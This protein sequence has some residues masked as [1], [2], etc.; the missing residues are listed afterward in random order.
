MFSSK[1]RIWLNR[2]RFSHTAWLIL[3]LLVGLAFIPSRQARADTPV[4]GSISTDTTWDLA[5]SPY[6]LTGSVTVLQN[7]TLTIEPG[8]VVQGQSNASLY[9]DGNLQALGQAGNPIVFTSQSDSAA[10]QWTGIQFSDGYGR[11]ENVIVR[12]GTINIDITSIQGGQELRIENSTLADPDDVS[13]DIPASYLHQMQM[14][15]NTFAGSAAR[16]RV[17]VSAGPIDGDVTLPA[18]PGLDAYQLGSFL[19][20]PTETVLTIEPGV[21][22]KTPA[23]SYLN[24]NGGLQAVGTPTEPITFTSTLDS[25]AD[26]WDGIQFNGGYGHLNYTTVRYGNQNIDIGSIQAGEQVRIENSTLADASDVALQI[27]PEVL[28]RVRLENN[29][30]AGDNPARQRVRLRFGSVSAGEMARL[31]AQPGLDA[32]ELGSFL[33]IPSGSTLVIS[34]GITIKTGSASEMTVN[35]NLQAVGTAEEPI[36]FTSILDSGPDQW[37]GLYFNGGYGHL[38]YATVR[39]G[40]R[41]IN[42]NDVQSGQQVRIENSTIADP[43]EIAVS[44]E[45]GSLHQMIMH[46]TTFSGQFPNRNRVGIGFGTLAGN[47]T[48]T[49]G[50]QTGLD[51]YELAG[52]VTVPDTSRLIIEPGVTIKARES[53]SLTVQGSLRA[54]GT[55]TEPVTFTSVL[56]TGE[57]QWDSLVFDGGY[58]HLNYA[59]V[60]YAG[61]DAINGNIRIWNILA[62]QELRI[63]NSALLTSDGSGLTMDNGNVSII[64]TTISDNHIGGIAQRGGEL[65]LNNVTIA[66][67][68]GGAGLNVSGGTLTMQNTLVAKNGSPEQPTDCAGTVVSARRNLFGSI[69]ECDYTPGLGDLTGNTGSVLDPRLGPL[70]DNGGPTLTHALLE[71][72][73]AIDS[74]NN[75]TCA[76]TDQRG[77][78]R[79]LGA[80]CDIGAYET[81]GP[82]VSSSLVRTVSTLTAR[83]G[84]TLTYSITLSVDEAATITLVD[85]LASG[86]NY[87][88]NSASS[89]ATYD[90]ATHQIRFTG[91]VTPE[92]PLTISYQAMID[93]ADVAPGSILSNVATVAGLGGVPEES[94]TVVV[95]NLVNV[96][97]LLL[98]YYGADNNLA[99]DGSEL[100]NSAEQAAGNSNVVILMMLDGPGS[101]DA[102]LYRLQQD[103]REGCPNYANPTCN[104]RYRLNENMWQ[105]TELTADAATLAEFISGALQ[106]YPNAQQVIL[107]LVGH[108]SGISAEG[109]SAQ[110]S[111]RKARTDEVAG[112]LIDNNPAGT[113]LSTRALA[114]GLRQ[115]LELAQAAGVERTRIDGLYLDACLMGM[116]EVAYE[117]R[118]STAYLLA[119]SNIKWAVADYASYIEAIDGQKSARQLLE[120]WMQRETSI[121]R[122]GGYPHTYALIDLSQ[123]EAVRA[124]L[125]SL[126]AALTQALPGGRASI[127]TAF[128]SAEFFDSSSDGT[129]DPAEDH[130]VDLLTFVQGLNTAFATDPTITAAAQDVEQAL[131]SAVLAQTQE[132]GIPFPETPDVRW[133]WDQDLGGLSIYLPLNQNDW[134]RRI[135]TDEHFQFAGSSQWDE[136]LTSYWDNQEPAQTPAGP[137]SP[138]APFEYQA[139]A[140]NAVYLPVVRR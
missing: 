100:L 97:T 75:I 40:N 57:G 15:N 62:G 138:A 78:A 125:D 114:E 139:R 86:L 18:Q 73:P 65:T 67:N 102:Y 135:Y 71:G 105:W 116:V 87:V 32:Y 117:I 3:L 119:S 47:S 93:A 31:P 16:S 66:E 1:S 122:Q 118:D 88:D 53:V 131:S 108:G 7:V 112:L 60:R 64:N 10:G 24:V 33:T 82:Q 30:F 69:S 8:V 106:A 110:P 92:S 85:T 76:A 123:L 91:V 37:T 51:A 58:G 23:N 22:V 140:G 81:Q 50:P 20:I 70:A 95:E 84:D 68:T 21:T 107:S 109:L 72:S 113:S 19:T 52:S 99:A 41:N 101:N 134:K 12:Y 46:N 90:A 26:Q 133:D 54:I 43:E 104:G 9:I 28:H 42:I 136:F 14:R 83:P 39:Y 38:N 96:N 115:G 4:S 124:A 45:P 126:A 137:G 132:S 63:E 74:G 61:K 128:D 89:G 129:I 6:I 98:I 80:V 29:T 44:I 127:D 49:L 5:G 94:I 48:V 25:G 35:G 77:V 13:I 103:D 2:M 55:L 130:Y 27:E 17:R 11:L 121:L 56:D 79:P 111:R 59:T 34:P 120:A 36:I